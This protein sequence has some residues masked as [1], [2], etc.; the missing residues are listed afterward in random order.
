MAIEPTSADFRAMIEA[1]PEAV[2]VYTFEKFLYLNPFAA[3]RLGSTPERLVG[4]RI[5][6]FVAP[7]SMR[8]VER[9]LLEL[10]RG[11]KVGEPVD[12]SF[13]SKD[14]TVIPAEI[15]S[16]PIVFAG[17]RA[18]LG[19]IRDM[20]RRNDIERALRESEERFANAFRQSPHGMAFVDFE[21][22]WLRANHALCEML[23]YSEEELRGRRFADMTHPDDVGIDLEQLQRL[24]SGEIGS[25]HRIKRYVRKDGRVVWVSLG[26]SAV[27]DQMGKPMYCIGQ[28]EDITLRRAM[29][30]ERAEGARLAGIVETT[31]AVAHEMNNA[32]TVLMLNAELLDK[33]VNPAELPEIS[34]EI[35]AASASIAGIVQ[36]LRQIGDLTTVDYLGEAKMLDLSS[37]PKPSEEG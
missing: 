9:R 11:E 7:E 17:Q 29:E 4:E 2:I 19:L 8:T 20:S 26:V 1:A 34:R 16:M 15:V 3:R 32:L 18:F 22:R 13:V 35:V 33:D 25:Y 12:V 30:E 6:E 21:G 23:G 28:M 14:G 5:L 27:H 10:A 37:R 24:I 31:I 36:R